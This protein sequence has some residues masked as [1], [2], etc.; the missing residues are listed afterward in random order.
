MIITNLIF[1]AYLN[2]PLK[3]FLLSTNARGATDSYDRWVGMENASYRHTLEKRFAAE[4]PPSEC[5]IH[6]EAIKNVKAAKW[7]LVLGVTSG[8]G[9]RV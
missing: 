5:L 8:K 4:I 3:C 2:C 6:P 7:Q 1:E 9:I